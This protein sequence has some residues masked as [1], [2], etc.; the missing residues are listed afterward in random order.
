LNL[1]SVS[2]SLEE[3]RNLESDVDN[4]KASLPTTISSIHEVIETEN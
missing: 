2:G 4:V 1:S 3:I